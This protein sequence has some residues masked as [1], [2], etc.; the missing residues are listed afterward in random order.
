MLTPYVLSKCVF[1]NS[2][3]LRLLLVPLRRTL[4]TA[5]AAHTGADPRERFEAS[6]VLAGVGDAL[7]YKNGSWEFCRSGERIHAEAERLGG[8]GSIRVDKKDWMVSDD[9]V[10]HI[11]TAEALLTKWA[12]DY[13]A[14]FT[15]LAQ[16]YKECMH[17]MAG[18]APGLTCSS[19]AHM[20]K[21][22]VKRGYVIPFDPRGG[23]CGAAMR[24]APIGLYFSKPEQI[25]ELVKV[26]VESG[27]MTH[28]HPT[29]YLGSLAVALFVSYSVQK[30]PLREWGAGLMETLDKAKEYVMEN[31]PARDKEAHREAWSYFEQHWRKYLTTRGLLDGQSD[32]VFTDHNTESVKARDAFYKSLSFSGT[33][34]ASG[35]DAP[36]IA[37]EAL[38]NVYKPIDPPMGDVE[39]KERQWFELCERSMLHGGDSDSTGI[40]AAACWGAMEGYAGVPKGHYKELEYRDRLKKLA[41][42]LFDE[43]KK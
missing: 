16:Q 42:K 3:G 8:V 23:G 30:K 7:G 6:M 2:R 22:N 26:A 1:L 25:E 20:L 38:L 27:R 17:D 11:A 5:M 21:P 28:N 31:S 29:G 18:R 10:M 19:S 15:A 43:T 37:Y 4:F 36:M 14:L 32:P 24:A 39:V 40:I 41:K 35:H 34:G 33:G 13:E 12:D 9:T